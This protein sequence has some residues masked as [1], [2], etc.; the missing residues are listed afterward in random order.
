MK[1]LLVCALALCVGAQVMADDLIPA[2]FR[3]APGTTFNKWTY[4]DP[5]NVYDGD[6]PENSWFVSHPDK[7]DPCL[8]DPCLPYFSAQ[9]WGTN[10]DPCAPVWYYSIAGR[11]GV[12]DFAYGSW[13]INNFIHDQPSKDIWVQVTY[14]NQSMQPVEVDYAGA[15]T[16]NVYDPCAPAL[17]YDAQLVSS[18][19]LDD[20]WIHEVFCV[21]IRPNPDSEWFEIMFVEPVL[22]DQIVIETLCYPAGPIY[23]YGDAPDDPCTPMYPTLS[24]NNG[25]RHDF[26]SGRPWLGPAYDGPDPEIDGQPHPSGLGDDGDEHDDEDGVT[27][28]T[29]VENQLGTI[30]VQ[31]NGGEGGAYVDV[32][33]DFNGDMDWNDAGEKIYA[34]GPDPD[35]IYNIAVTPP[36][37][38]AGTTFL[39]ARIN[40]TGPLPPD[41]PAQDGEVEDHKVIII[42]PG[43]KWSQPPVEISEPTEPPTYYGWDEPSVYDPNFPIVADDW[44]CTDW[45]PV[46]DVHW[47]GSYVGWNPAEPAPPQVVPTGFHIGI[48]TDVP[49]PDPCNPQNYSHPK[50]M[51]WE[52]N[53]SMAEVNE[54][55][56]GWDTHPEHDYDMCFKYDLQLPEDDVFCQDPNRGVFWLS[57]AAIYDGVA[58]VDHVW[59]WKTREHFWNDDAIILQFS[60]VP[61]T[62]AEYEGGVPIENIEGSWDMAFELT[63]NPE[64]CC[65]CGDFDHNGT[66]D[67]NDVR[68]LAKNWLWAGIPG[69]YNIADLNCDGKIDYEDFAI[70]AL[71]WLVS[72]P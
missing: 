38:S 3:G 31:A 34:S 2:P 21:T 14:I 27:I 57:I 67:L 40:T 43:R 56:D 8:M 71:Q 46:S 20:G 72:C 69:G 23:D 68:I 52:Y 44:E 10:G 64:H 13:D 15:G 16:D 1:L 66:I 30:T 9:L 50:K 63:T 11:Y 12:I 25:A 55:F 5:C 70:F 39:R 53:A 45:R 4:D 47:W 35:G 41:G 54:D 65:D 51:I 26:T 24:S 36:L 6:W 28:P 19:I 33:I 58:P 60:E 59:G 42:E 61:T 49:D 62:G 48:W 18:Q 29:L 32:W 7:L 37:G 17:W 22:I